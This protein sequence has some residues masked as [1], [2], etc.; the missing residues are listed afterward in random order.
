MRIQLAVSEMVNNAVVHGEGEITLVID[1]QDDRLRLEVIDEGTDPART[2]RPR[3]PD[4]EGG[5]GLH[6]IAGVADA[7]G[8]YDGTTHVWCDFAL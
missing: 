5:R 7:W 4:T 2:V 3:E 6:I 8:V 1:R